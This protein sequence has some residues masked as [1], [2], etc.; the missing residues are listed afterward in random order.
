M[1][2]IVLLFALLCLLGCQRG[3]MP[4]QQRS[5]LDNFAVGDTSGPLGGIAI[6]N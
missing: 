1:K 5:I 3:T 4:V 2:K 6:G